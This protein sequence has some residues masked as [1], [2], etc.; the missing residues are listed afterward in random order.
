VRR[1]SADPPTP[2]GPSVTLEVAYEPDDAALDEA[3]G[4]LL[5]DDAAATPREAA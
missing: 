2:S 3:I 1:H 5:G 4:I